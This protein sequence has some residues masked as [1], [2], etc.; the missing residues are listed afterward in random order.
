MGAK[1]KM[2][3]EIVALWKRSGFL[4]GGDWA[5]PDGM[6]VQRVTGI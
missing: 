2:A 6:H 5:S 1:P 3:P 4:W